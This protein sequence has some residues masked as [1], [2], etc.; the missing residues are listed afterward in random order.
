M[1]TALND[2]RKEKQLIVITSEITYTDVLF[3]AGWH[4]HA[5]L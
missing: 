5:L 3:K 4:L 2:T 1:Q